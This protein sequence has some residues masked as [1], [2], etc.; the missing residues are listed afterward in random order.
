[1]FWALLECVRSWDVGEDQQ[2]PRETQWLGVFP[3]KYSFE[4]LKACISYGLLIPND[5]HFNPVVG[6]G[7][8]VDG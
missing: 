4:P 8:F 1:M 2:Q 3:D 7:I 5:F 6:G